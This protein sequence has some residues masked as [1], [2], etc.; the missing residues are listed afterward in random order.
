MEGGA[1]LRGVPA[2]PLLTRPRSLTAR[3]PRRGA[4]TTRHGS[5]SPGNQACRNGDVHRG[6]NR[7][8]DSRYTNRRAQ[9]ER[10]R[11]RCS[12]LEILVRSSLDS[13][14]RKQC[15]S[16]L[17]HESRHHST[18]QDTLII[19]VR[20]P[21]PVQNP[22]VDSE[23]ASADSHASPVLGHRSH[24][25]NLKRELLPNVEPATNT[26]AAMGT[27]SID[28]RYRRCLPYDLNR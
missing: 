3:H 19:L 18:L 1:A 28:V 11:I 22:E 6:G 25:P 24:N 12:F 5:R 16:C 14:R 15:R 27:S 10:P 21:R 7:P 17:S 23:V 9:Q 4:R 2:P 13:A 20:C 8:C 26:P